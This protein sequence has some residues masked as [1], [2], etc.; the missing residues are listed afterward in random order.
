[1]HKGTELFAGINFIEHYDPLILCG[2]GG[3]FIEVLKEMPITLMTRP[4]GWDTL[5]VKVYE[6]TSE[7]E[8]V[9][10]SLPSLFIVL[11]ATGSVLIINL[12]FQRKELK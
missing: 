12:H 2:L 9:R 6:F 8:W 7:G 4:Y 10:A 11:L 3:I 1:M 5:A